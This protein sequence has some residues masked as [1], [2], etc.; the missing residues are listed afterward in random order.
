MYL[1]KKIMPLIDK[2]I[3]L[4][5]PLI[6][7]G[8]VEKNFFLIANFL[9]TKFK[10]IYICSAYIK[11]NQNLIKILFLLILKNLFRNLFFIYLKSFLLLIK[12]Y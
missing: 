7:G 10:R 4:F 2:K 11:Y 1:D 8:G 3:L 5:M 6:G 12:F 9:A